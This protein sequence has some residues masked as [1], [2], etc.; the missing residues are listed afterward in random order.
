MSIK[1]TGNPQIDTATAEIAVALRDGG[2]GRRDQD[3]YDEAMR[4]RDEIL[5]GADKQQALVRELAGNY[6]SNL[7]SAD[8]AMSAIAAAV[9][10]TAGE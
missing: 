8:S 5:A 10:S 4:L 9:L 2:F 3:R 6:H 1:T 7:L